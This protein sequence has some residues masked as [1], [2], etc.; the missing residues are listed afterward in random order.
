M[1]ELLRLQKTQ[2]EGRASFNAYNPEPPITHTL[3]TLPG[4][5]KGKVDVPAELRIKNRLSET[6]VRR[7]IAQ[8]QQQARSHPECRSCGGCKR[9]ITCN[10]DPRTCSSCHTLFHRS[11]SGLTRDV[12]ASALARTSWIYRRYTTAPPQLRQKPLQASRFVS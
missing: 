11:Y 7:P 3:S 8:R 4:D 10:F 6:V 1:T 2:D 12:A 5:A 9:T